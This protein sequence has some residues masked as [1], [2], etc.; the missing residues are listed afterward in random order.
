MNQ[1]AHSG[2]ELGASFRNVTSLKTGSKQS[3]YEMKVVDTSKWTPL[4]YEPSR[5][6]HPATL[7]VFIHL[8]IS[9]SRNETGMFPA[10]VPQFVESLYISND[11]PSTPGAECYGYCSSTARGQGELATDVVAF[12]SETKRPL[13]ILDGCKSVP[14]YG[15]VA[16][17]REKAQGEKSSALEKWMFGSDSSNVEDKQSMVHCSPSWQLD[18]DMTPKET[19][20]SVLQSLVKSTSSR[21]VDLVRGLQSLSQKPF[22]E[23]LKDANFYN[24]YTPSSAGSREDLTLQDAAMHKDNASHLMSILSPPKT[25]NASSVHS[26]EDGC[27]SPAGSVD[28][29]DPLDAVLDRFLDLVL[30]KWWDCGLLEVTKNGEEARL[31][32]LLDSKANKGAGC[33]LD[34]AGQRS[35]N[36]SLDSV[37]DESSPDTKQQREI[38]FGKPLSEQ[39]FRANG[40][41]VIMI[42]GCS[43]DERATA[44]THCKEALTT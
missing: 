43:P 12:S 14:L 39:G 2:F 6:I 5:L 29:S 44:V 16:R 9:T 28:E 33:W 21:G 36:N 22:G 32:S 19:L 31:K 10:R 8:L 24:T 37:S 26:Q 18:L 11:F 38:D 27:F 4:N 15:S 20:Q 23:H 30:H 42:H 1:A 17:R 40:Y 35:S 3:T 34:V 41:N 25:E 7:D 13:I